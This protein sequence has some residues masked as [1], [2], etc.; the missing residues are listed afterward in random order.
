[1]THLPSNSGP[2]KQFNQNDSKIKERISIIRITASQYQIILY[3]SG[4]TVQ[5]LQYK[6]SKKKREWYAMSN[7]TC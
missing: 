3:L 4:H 6:Y 1:M 2:K 7:S 5:E